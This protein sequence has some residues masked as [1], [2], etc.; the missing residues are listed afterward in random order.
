C[1]N[2]RPYS[3][4]PDNAAQVIRVGVEA[5]PS[6]RVQQPH[7]SLGPALTVNGY[8]ARRLAIDRLSPVRYSPFEDESFE[9]EAH[10]V[11]GSEVVVGCR[12]GPVCDHVVPGFGGIPDGFV[13][14][15]APEIQQ[16][17]FAD[18]ARAALI[19]VPAIL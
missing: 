7:E 13:I 3:R 4:L 8:K 10:R 18:A 17:H 12:D 1:R 19:Y 6:S 14:T 16:C 2:R 15:L 9:P 11:L 5:L